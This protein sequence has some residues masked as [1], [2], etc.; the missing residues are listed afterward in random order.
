[1]KKSISFIL[2]SLFTVSLISAQSL[3][4]Q[5]VGNLP[6]EFSYLTEEFHIEDQGGGSYMAEAKGGE[7]YYIMLN[8]ASSRYNADSLRYTFTNLYKEDPSVENIQVNEV[9]SGKLG[10]LDGE[11]V[12]I[13][14]M[15][16]GGYYTATALLVRFHLNRKYNSFLLT[17]EMSERS[18][19]NKIRYDAVKK[20]FE[21]LASSF[22]Y[23]EFKYKKY[24]YTKDSISIDYPDFWYA[25]KNDTSM[26]IDD[27][28]CKVTEIAY[29]AKDSTTT[30][31][32]AK[33]ERDAMKKNSALYP[34]F[35]GSL[36]RE[37]WRNDELCTKFS[38]SYE[39]DEFGARKTR[40]FTKYIIRRNVGGKMKDFHVYFECPEMYSTYYTGVFE[41]MLK[42]LQLPGIAAEVKK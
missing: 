4:T 14:F 1:M 20:G 18:E 6:V 32:H 17:Y 7:V 8:K 23:K 3:S 30:E 26:L 12:R 42:S 15:S 19:A 22:V 29:I 11:R 28:R 5:A 9:G 2:T 31:T 16:N 13:T 39:Y 36:T 41:I 38:G 35:K 34:S 27:G 24:T 21:D 10:N 25:G 40:S 33:C 37:N